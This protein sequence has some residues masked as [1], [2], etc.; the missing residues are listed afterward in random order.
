MVLCES[1]LLLQSFD[2]LVFTIS[3]GMSVPAK[4]LGRFS[5]TGK[6]SKSVTIIRQTFERINLGLIIIVPWAEN[7]SVKSSMPA[8]IHAY[9]RDFR[10]LPPSSFLRFDED[11]T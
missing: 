4:Q 1:G 8:Q 2:T 11:A 10:A 5:G 7:I 6:G 3:S 9:Q